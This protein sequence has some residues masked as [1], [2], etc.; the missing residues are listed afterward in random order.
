[1]ADSHDP[2]AMT[3][4][5]AGSFNGTSHQAGDPIDVDA[6]YVE[7]LTLSGFAAR[8]DTTDPEKP[9]TARKAKR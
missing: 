1:M 8:R 2:V 4:L 5:R 7:V 9:P 3:V 6:V